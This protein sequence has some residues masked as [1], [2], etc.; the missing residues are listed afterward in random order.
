MEVQALD[1]CFE[2]VLNR[3]KSPFIP[4]CGDVY[5]VGKGLN[6]YVNEIKMSISMDFIYVRLKIDSLLSE[7]SI[8]YLKSCGW[9]ELNINGDE[10]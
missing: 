10:S 7:E 4:R 1:R 8:T 3:K 5:F 6:F 9:R 2:M